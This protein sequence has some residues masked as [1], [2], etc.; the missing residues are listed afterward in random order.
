MEVHSLNIAKVF[1]C[2]YSDK[3]INIIVVKFKFI[4]KILLTDKV[5]PIL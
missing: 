3:L 1:S 5:F 4:F 2:Y